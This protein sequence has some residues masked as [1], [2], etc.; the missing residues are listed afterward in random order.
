MVYTS[1][2]IVNQTTS[3]PYWSRTTPTGGWTCFDDGCCSWS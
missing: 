1:H 3:N 2:E